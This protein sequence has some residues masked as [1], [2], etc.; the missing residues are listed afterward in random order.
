M[1]QVA[2]AGRQLA[3][4]R[5]RMR[6]LARKW[7]GGSEE[8]KPRETSCAQKRVARC[9][10]R[11][12]GGHDS[13]PD[14]SEHW[15]AVGKWPLL[16]KSRIYKLYYMSTNQGHGVDVHNR[17]RPRPA[18]SWQ[19]P[20]TPLKP[21]RGPRAFVLELVMSQFNH[22]LAELLAMLNEIKAFF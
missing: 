7:D 22:N 9:G 20:L 18:A 6:R 3:S 2:R 13:V 12:R 14:R 17:L 16:Y 21:T 5:E 4:H 11:L 19:T 1:K 10:R 8:S 15:R